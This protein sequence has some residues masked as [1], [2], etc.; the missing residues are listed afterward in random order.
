MKL[1]RYTNGRW[2]VR[3]TRNGKRRMLST[4]ETDKT[5]ALLK[6]GEIQRRIENE[7]AQG[8]PA[9]APRT[10]AAYANEYLEYSKA[11]KKISSF[12]RDETSL[13]QILPAFGDMKLSEITTRDIEQ[14]QT[15]RS[16]K[17]A[18]ATANRDMETIKHMMNKAVDWNYIKA[19]PARQI[20]R[21]RT[22]PP[23]TRFL[24][25]EERDRLLF[26][27]SANPMLWAIVFTALETGMRRGELMGLTWK[28]INFERRSI[29]LMRTKNNEQR[30]IPISDKL[31]PVLERLNIERKGQTV[32]RKPDGRPYGNWRKAFETACNRA[33]VVD[34]R[35]HDLRHTF[36]S[37][38]VMAGVDIRTVQELLG[39]KDIKMT[40]R[41]SHLSRPHLLDA[42]NKGGTNLAHKGN[43]AVF[44]SNKL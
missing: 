11:H 13:N 8:I 39:H 18:P 36:A 16:L 9:D 33:G 19:N 12:R 21:L 17:V 32:F 24:S 3:Y 40:L 31:L 10:F 34:F 26:E 23:P 29:L 14:F 27:C 6:V 41:Y 38:L 37:Y 5:Q 22:P 43:T 20:K 35:F 30:M 42:V 7:T 15:Q 25:C 1:Y 28:D 2:Y 4:G 44:E